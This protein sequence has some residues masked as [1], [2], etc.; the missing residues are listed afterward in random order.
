MIM[1]EVP[2]VSLV[3]R[4]LSGLSSQVDSLLRKTNATVGPTDARSI[5][6][7]IQQFDRMATSSR[8]DRH[9]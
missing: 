3:M 7:Q 8:A 5:G 9:R 2:N 1:T 6:Q 4:E